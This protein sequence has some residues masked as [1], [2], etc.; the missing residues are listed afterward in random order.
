MLD[1]LATLLQYYAP[2]APQEQDPEPATLPPVE[3]PLAASQTQS[4]S[5]EEQGPE[6]RTPTAI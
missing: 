5:P 4:P 1:E 6:E 2:S 3:Q